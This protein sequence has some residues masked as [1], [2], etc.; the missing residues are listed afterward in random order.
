M[1]LSLPLSK[2]D[3]RADEPLNLDKDKCLYEFKCYYY[4]LYLN[5]TFEQTNR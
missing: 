1:L 2:F 3:V 5:L 4:F